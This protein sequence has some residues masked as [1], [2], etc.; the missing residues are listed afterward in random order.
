MEVD[1]VDRVYLSE[2]LDEID[3]LDFTTGHRHRSFQ[4]V[5]T[6]GTK[7]LDVES[8]EVPDGRAGRSALSAGEEPPDEEAR[9][10]RGQGDQHHDAGDRGGRGQRCGPGG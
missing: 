1:A 5:Q 3:Q 2:E 10:Y 8:R 4:D 9:Q 7:F 6:E